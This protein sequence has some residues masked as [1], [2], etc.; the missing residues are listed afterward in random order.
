MLHDTAIALVHDGRLVAAVE[1]ERFTRVKHQAGLFNGGGM[2][3]NSLRWI[4]SNYGA[5]P[6]DIDRFCYA[7]AVDLYPS[8]LKAQV[9]TLRRHAK[10]LDSG[11]ERSLFLDHHYCHA[12]SAFAGSGFE[13]ALIV[14]VDGEGDAVSIMLA[15]V[16]PEGIKPILRL[17]PSSSLGHLYTK[18]TRA[19]G[20]LA[21]G[22]EGKVMALAEH[23]ERS[24]FDQWGTPVVVDSETG[25]VEVDWQ[26]VRLLCSEACD[27]NSA[28][29]RQVELAGALQNTLEHALCQLVLFGIARTGLAK[30]CLA[31][32]VA[33][34][35]C[36]NRAISLLP[37]VE[38]LFV[39]F[40]AGDQG[41]A[42]GAA[43]LG[44]AL[45]C[46]TMHGHSYN[47]P[48]LGPSYSQ[49]ECRQELQS[50]GIS[51]VQPEQPEQLAARLILDNMVV[52]WLSG[53]AEFGPRALGARSIFAASHLPGIS[54]RLNCQVKHRATWRPFAPMVL[55]FDGHTLFEEPCQNPYMTSTAKVSP[56][57]RHLLSQTISARSTSRLQTVMPEKLPDVACILEEI[58]RET[59]AGTLLNTSFNDAGEPM[60]LSPRDALRTFFSTGLDHLFLSGLWVAKRDAK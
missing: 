47:S 58:R 12:V 25:L 16:G 22:D 19:M 57:A 4:L 41:T 38:A 39:P 27:V 18:V 10:E 56:K 5:Y 54:D 43:L 21:Y 32:G 3:L 31:G 23:S 7:G 29:D 34:N 59:G 51:Y 45:Y 2:P 14:T 44:D 60:V 40:C 30:V 6:Q 55:E 52:G 1:E 33:L 28:F 11:M 15:A 13:R 20:F 48:Y 46:A 8:F 53:R 37:E 42:I 50:S 49:D 36:A 26:A 9:E 17:P 35:C 24:S